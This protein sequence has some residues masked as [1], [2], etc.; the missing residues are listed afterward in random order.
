MQLF[1]FIQNGNTTE[2]FFS[3]SDR[4]DRIRMVESNGIS[5][6]DLEEYASDRN[7]ILDNRAPWFHVH[8]GNDGIFLGKVSVAKNDFE[9]AMAYCSPAEHKAAVAEIKKNNAFI[10]Q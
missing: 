7:Y 4:Q 8:K 5:C 9:W 1:K 6:T 10:S 3:E 2:I